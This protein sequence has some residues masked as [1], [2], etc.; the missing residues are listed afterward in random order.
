MQAITGRKTGLLGCVAAA[1][2]TLA[3]G[4]LAAPVA[5]SATDEAQDARIARLE[6]ALASLESKVEHASVVEQENAELKGQVA[7]LQ[8]QVADLKSSTAD[9]LQDVRKTA[10][11][12]PTVS[13]ANGRPTFT[14]ADG[15]FSAALRG[16][17]QFDAAHYD[18][19]P[20]TAANDLASGTNVRRARLGVDGK[21]FGDWN[22]ALWGEF[23]GSGGEA[24]ILNQAYIEYAGLHLGGDASLRLRAGVWAPTSGL[25]DATSNSESLFL[26]RPAAAELIRG[27]DAG[28]GRTGLGFSANGGHWFASGTLTGK[29]V[30]VP[31]TAEV[32]QQEGFVAR[33]AFDPLHGPDFDTH[34]GAT[35]QGVIKPA[36]TAAGSPVAEAVR[37][38]ER[39]ELRVDGNSIR[40][41]DTGA[42]TSDGLISYGL[43]AGAS[44][45]NLYLAGEWFKFDVNRTAVGAAPSPFDPSFSGWYVQGAWT[46]TGERHQW[47]AASGRGRSPAD[48]ACWT[49]TT[50]RVRRAPRR[51]PAASAAASRRSPA[52]G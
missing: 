32:A 25:E 26:E 37:L 39:P 47:A 1:S 8:A 42:I 20:R 13:L 30:G 29:V 22:Y 16:I 40:L 52:S 38:R 4:A 21:A 7:D 49:S 19:S 34:L 31:A 28:D 9:Q 10:A 14:T 27:L 11:S 50:G 44:W 41:V 15:K 36:D 51:P 24:A 23:G 18:V 3:T 2:L 46:L 6:A 5:T 48:T 35:V 45:R 17:V 33:V 12:A 43:E